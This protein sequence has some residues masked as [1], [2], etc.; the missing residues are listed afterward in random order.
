MNDNRLTRAA[1]SVQEELRRALERHHER[2]RLQGNAGSGNRPGRG[3]QAGTGPTHRMPRVGDIEAR[4]WRNEGRNGPYYTVRLVRFFRGARG[5]GVAASLRP[6]DIADA[7][8]ALA[9]ARDWILAAER[10][11]TR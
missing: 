3:Q 10:R 2:M 5:P 8:A 1:D 7:T 11:H 6:R 9:R 4:I